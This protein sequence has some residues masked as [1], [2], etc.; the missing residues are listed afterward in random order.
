[1]GRK[2]LF[3]DDINSSY[4]GQGRIQDLVLEGGEGVNVVQSMPRARAEPMGVL[5]MF[6]IG[7]RKILHFRVNLLRSIFE[8]NC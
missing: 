2:C 3:P 7:K 5:Q 6:W 4:I 8:R 1:M